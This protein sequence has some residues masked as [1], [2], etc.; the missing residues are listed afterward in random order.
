[1]PLNDKK[2][3]SLPDLTRRELGKRTVEGLAG[4]ATDLIT[5]PFAGEAI[6]SIT[7]SSSV[8]PMTKNLVIEY[9]KLEDDLRKIFELNKYSSKWKRLDWHGQKEIDER[10][11]LE[12]PDIKALQDVDNAITDIVDAAETAKEDEI[13]KIE[14]EMFE[15]NNQEEAFEIQA[16][17]RRQKN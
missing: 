17:L 10:M 3:L 1:M 14:P 2:G 12:H 6:S 5:G 11:R 7:E 16:F 15:E 4:L 9:Y 13:K 8:F